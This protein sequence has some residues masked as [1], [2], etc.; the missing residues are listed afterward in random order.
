MSAP[1]KISRWEWNLEGGGPHV[2][3]IPHA[4]FTVDICV[5]TAERDMN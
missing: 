4:E 5:S 3:S 1:A 2:M